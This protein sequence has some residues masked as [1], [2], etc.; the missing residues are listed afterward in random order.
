MTI[1]LREPASRFPHVGRVEAIYVRRLERAVAIA[2]HGL[3]A[4][5]L[6]VI[7][8]LIGRQEIAPALLRRNLVIAGLIPI[9]SHAMTWDGYKSERVLN[10][11]VIPIGD[12]VCCIPVAPRS[13]DFSR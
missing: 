9:P 3:Q 5:H 1:D 6:P 11:G 8:S 12:T 4:E 7:A 13:A 2:W 10:R